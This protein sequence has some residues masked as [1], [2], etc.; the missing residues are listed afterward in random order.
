VPLDHLLLGL[1]REPASGYDIKR[2][3]DEAIGHFWAAELSQVYPALKRMERD[4]LLRSRST[5]SS[6]GPARTVYAVTAAGRRELRAWLAQPPR[7]R[8]ERIEWLAQLWFM[9]ETPEKALGFLKT[10]RSELAREVATLESVEQRWAAEDP[11]YPDVASSADFFRQVTLS[12]GLAKGRA[13]LQW[14][15]A[16]IERI[17]R[18]RAPPE[19]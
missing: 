13:R 5:P 7:M 18:R 16:C 14:A 3:F 11:A 4:G 8:S 17:K 19:E 10:L 12:L 6:R 9:D 2:A 15:D 1:L